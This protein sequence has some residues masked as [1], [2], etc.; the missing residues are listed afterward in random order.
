MD[1]VAHLCHPDMVQVKRGL[2]FVLKSS[3][4][5]SQNVQKGDFSLFDL[6]KIKIM[7]FSP[8]ITFGNGKESESGSFFFNVSLP[9]CE[10]WFPNCGNQ[11]GT[12][13]GPR[14]AN[15]EKINLASPEFLE[16][17]KRQLKRRY[18]LMS[19]S[20]KNCSFPT[21]INRKRFFV[22][23]TVISKRNSFSWPFYLDNR[24]TSKI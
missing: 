17:S 3:I 9:A 5:T 23:T 7:S 20:N 12:T 21:P 6:A 2:S 19:V 1:G 15:Q 11:N 16:F 10:S 24:R 13:V 14:D 8:D 18:F 4:F 22:E